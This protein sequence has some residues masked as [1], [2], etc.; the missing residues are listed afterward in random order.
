MAKIETRKRDA[1]YLYREW[2]TS[3]IAK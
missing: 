3:F 1:K 2:L